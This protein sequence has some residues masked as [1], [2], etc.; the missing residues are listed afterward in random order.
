MLELVSLFVLV[1]KQLEVDEALVL[2]VG[3]DE[4]F[5]VLLC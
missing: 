3:A 4:A 2:L 5:E 1:L